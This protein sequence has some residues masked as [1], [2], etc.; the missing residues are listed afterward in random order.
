MDSKTPLDQGMSAE[1]TRITA[2]IRKAIMDDKSMSMNAQNCKVI[3][4]KGVVTLRGPVDSDTE[5]TTIESKAKAV[6]GVVSVTNQLEVK[7]K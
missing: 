4:N 3:T 6:A 2:D 7:A 5:K 1:D